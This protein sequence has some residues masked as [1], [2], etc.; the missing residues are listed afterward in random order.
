MS[1]IVWAVCPQCN[2][3]IPAEYD[4]KLGYIGYRE[5]NPHWCPKCGTKWYTNYVSYTDTYTK[6]EGETEWTKVE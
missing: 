6:N 4:D 3:M 5:E 2:Y 1:T